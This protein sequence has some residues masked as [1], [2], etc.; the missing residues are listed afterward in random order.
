MSQ[1][2]S[3]VWGLE[4]IYLHPFE[5]GRGLLDDIKPLFDDLYPG[6]LFDGPFSISGRKA[7]LKL[8]GGDE[9]R[10]CG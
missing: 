10:L 1:D 7:C 5:R 3:G 8:A 9:S 6:Y 2:V 4:W